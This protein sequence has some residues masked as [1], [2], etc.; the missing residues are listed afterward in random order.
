MKL[1]TSKIEGEEAR[2]QSGFPLSFLD[3]V[4]QVTEKMGCVASFRAGQPPLA[5]KGYKTQP[6]P[7][8]IPTKSFNDAQGIPI[9]S[10]RVPGD[11]LLYRKGSKPLPEG[12]PLSRSRI[13]LKEIISD[14]NANVRID[15][16]YIVYKPG[17]TQDN[18]DACANPELGDAE[19]RIK[20]N[21]AG[22][23]PDIVYTQEEKIKNQPHLEITDVT[24][25][26]FWPDDWGNFDAMTDNLF[27]LEIKPKN[28]D[29]K[30]LMDGG[31]PPLTGDVDA[32]AFM[33]SKQFREE[34]PEAAEKFNISI[35]NEIIE[36]YTQLVLLE[37]KFH[38]VPGISQLNFEAKDF[39]DWVSELK[40]T[41]PTGIATPAEVYVSMAIN[42]QSTKESTIKHMV[43]PVLHGPETNNPYNPSPL[44][45]NVLFVQGNKSELTCDP[46]SLAI[47]MFTLKTKGL[48][49]NLH[50]GWPKEFTHTIVPRASISNL[51][52]TASPEPRRKRT[53]MTSPPKSPDMAKPDKAKPNISDVRSLVKSGKKI[54]DAAEKKESQV[55]NSPSTPSNKDE[56]PKHGK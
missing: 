27:E 24:K 10:G 33:F 30:P 18:I 45:G 7:G 35:T 37:E 4:S 12:T 19:F 39:E 46:K 41:L 3:A 55:T 48:E 40:T 1:K 6:K 22:T 51:T 43:E 21:G 11:P 38:L 36:C 15:G 20:V 53:P 5:N 16:D 47:K 42:Y 14:P 56:G 17:M 9:L 28:Q 31:N 2:K 32:F 54:I 25:P 50:E 23:P 49:T 44:D 26:D 8:S 13:A 34:N 29:W 52:P